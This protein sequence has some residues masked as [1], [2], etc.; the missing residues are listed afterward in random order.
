MSSRS[1]LR[2]PLLP[3]RGCLLLTLCLL[4]LGVAFDPQPRAFAAQLPATVPQY[5]LF[6]LPITAAQ[7]QIDTAQI[8]PY[9]PEQVDVRVRFTAPSGKEHLISAFWMQAYRDTCL[10]DCKTEVLEA[11]GKAGWRARFA[12]DEPGF[13]SY[14]VQRGVSR[15]A[16]QTVVWSEALQQGEF[17]VVASANPGPIRVAQ[18]RRYFVRAN[19]DSYFPV[20][21]NL[22]WSWEGA[23]GTRGYLDWLRRLQQVGA[24]YGRLYI[25]VPWFIGFDWRGRPGNYL[26][27]QEDSW[28]L[29]AILSQAEEYGIALQI[30]LVWHQGFINY[31]GLPVIVP[32]TPARPNTEADW[33]SNPL[34]V[35]RGGPLP[36]AISFFTTDDGRDLLKRRLRYVV[37]RWGYSSSVFA[38]E[39]IDQLDRAVSTETATDWLRDLVDYLRRTDPYA[40]LIT[41]GVRDAASRNLLAPVPLDFNQTRFFQRRPI[42]PAADQVLGTLNALNPLLTVADRPAMLTEF[43]LGPWFEPTADDPTG[44]HLMQSMWA[45]ALSGAGGGAASWWWDT[46]FFPQNLETTLAPLAAFAQ[47]VPW[48]SSNLVPASL[49]ISTLSPLPVEPLTVTGFGGAFGA[50]PGPDVTYRLTPDGAFPPLAGQSAYLYGLAYNAQFSRP[51]RYVITPPT[52]TTLTV[53]VRRVSDQAPAKLVVIIDG[54]TAGQ[55]EFSAGNT[56]VS[57]TV[58]IRAGERSVIIDNLGEDFLE[59]D[60]LVIGA[61]ITPL[62]TLALADRERGL[63]LAWVQHRQYTWEN[64]ANSVAILPVTVSL[65]L[66]G[67]PAGLYRVELWDPASGNVIGVEQVTTAGSPTGTLTMTLLPLKTMVALRA[68]H[69]AQPGNLP[70]LTPVPTATPRQLPTL[71]ATSSPL[72]SATAEAGIIN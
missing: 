72:P 43:S 40:H 50:P 33:S 8:N 2:L 57:M 20:G 6:E 5:G 53:N 30:V 44:L 61:Y 17:E 49:S 35:V 16:G 71:P 18:N 34:N 68:F 21:V 19:G 23:G 69:I 27:A 56:N 45:S 58:P 47:G 13:W 12:P 10:R 54:E 9:D 39:V 32:T 29:D 28:R 42:E 36:A 48:A 38:W 11:A 55:A 60:S 46:Y 52:D 65:R 63:V 7:T 31:G 70:T 4:L 64:V 14:A 3:L 41:A 22:G 24:T 15:E 62:R 37:S 67:L 66:G 26:I 59:L 1:P 25:D 51:Q